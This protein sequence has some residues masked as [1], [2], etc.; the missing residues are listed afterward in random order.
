MR[1]PSGDAGRSPASRVT[2]PICGTLSPGW[3]AN[4]GDAG[5]GRA[6]RG[7]DLTRLEG[8]STLQRYPKVGDVGMAHLVGL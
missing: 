5:P 4:V 6:S 8:D 2:S 7:L 3:D 1:R